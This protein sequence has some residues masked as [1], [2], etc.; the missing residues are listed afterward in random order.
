[1]KYHLIKEDNSKFFF[2]S[3]LTYGLE[4]FPRGKN[5]IKIKR[6]IITDQKL[7]DDYVTKRINKKFN[8]LFSDMYKI[9]ISE[10]DDSTSDQTAMVLDEIAKLK[11]VVIGK[12]KDYISLKEY[13]NILKKLIIA[14][15]EFAKDYN[16]KL[17]FEAFMSQFEETKSHGR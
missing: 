9:L 17:R 3:S 12:Y 14:Q 5:V 2:Y 16:E 4:V 11:S 1:M 10:N 7:I 6:M 13:K 15:E 8:K